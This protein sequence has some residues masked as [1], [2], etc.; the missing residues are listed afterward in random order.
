M[1]PAQITIQ[2]F[3]IH[4]FGIF[5]LVGFLLLAFGVW[6]EGKKDGFSEEKLFDLLLFLFHDNTGLYQHNSYLFDR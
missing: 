2:N 6:S 1:M 3:T 4:T 5:I